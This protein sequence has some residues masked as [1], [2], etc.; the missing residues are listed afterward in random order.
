MNKKLYILPLMLGLTLGLE[1]V[2]KSLSFGQGDEVELPREPVDLGAHDGEYVLVDALVLLEVVSQESMPPIE[3]SPQG[4]VRRGL[5]NALNGKDF[6]MLADSF[7]GHPISRESLKRLE[8]STRNLMTLSGKP[9]S[10]VYLPE[11][12]ITEGQVRLVV[13][14]SRIGEIRIQGNQY[15]SDASYLSRFGF[16]EGETID[17]NAL[18]PGIA[19]I[20]RS[21][22]R[23]ATVK[24]VRGSEPGTSDI[25]IVTQEQ[26]PWK[27]FAGVNN[28]GT[29]ST[30]EIRLTA[31]V[32]YGDL[33]GLDHQLS[34]QWSSDPGADHS[35]SL[36]GS[37][38]VPVGLKGDL[39]LFGSQ[40]WTN[41]KV[42]PPLMQEGGSYQLGL[43][44]DYEL[45]PAGQRY[46]HSWQV[47]IDFKSS[48]NNLDY[49]IPPF[50]IP[51]SDNLTHVVQGRLQYR[52]TFIDG[53]GYTRGTITAVYSPGD[54]SSHNTDEDFSGTRA[55]AEA[56]Y[57]YGKLSFFRDTRFGGAFEGWNWTLQADLQIASGNLMG[58]EQFSAGGSATVRGYEEGEAIGDNGF[59]LSQ[60]LQ[61][62]AMETKV[63]L[64]GRSYPGQLRCFIFQDYAE[65]WNQ[66]KL[67]GEEPFDLMS[68]GAGLNYQMGRY[69]S[70]QVTHGVQLRDS[71]SSDS[72]DNSRTHFS[73]TLS[74]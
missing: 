67:T 43:N 15:F 72:G 33:W 8:S 71:G 1:A 64:L 27:V 65:T 11:Q 17:R 56:D 61:L 37:Y 69:L 19:K 63:N 44:F 47:G 5:P 48:D 23:S 53:W 62:P 6:E 18:V 3:G 2:Q 45:E 42:S 66:D 49:A 39:T 7:L 50:V 24:V 10:L 31:G 46:Q 59:L 9:Y 22:Y 38:T 41:A 70:A 28:S 12:D 34:L 25:V 21:D 60:E 13:Q 58:S 29:Q 14:E 51:I 68:V 16:L 30:E 20:N 36:S 57:V 54:L 32:N 74:Y 55:F 35:R 26:K 40:S 4:L 52:G 73:L